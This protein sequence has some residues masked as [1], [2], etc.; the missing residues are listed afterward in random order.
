LNIIALIFV[1]ITLILGVY[2]KW[3]ALAGILLL[4]MYYFAHPPFPG[5]EQYNVEGSYWFVNKNLIEIASLWI[6]Y[7]LPT[8]YYFGIKYL[9]DKRSTVKSPQL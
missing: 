6:L 5:L 3:G 7:Q 1:G 8:G 9:I 2:E 4:G